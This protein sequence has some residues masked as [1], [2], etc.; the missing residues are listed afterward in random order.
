MKIL[1]ACDFDHTIIDDNSDT[2]IVQLCPDKTVPSDIKSRYQLHQS[3]TDYMDEIFK[4]MHSKDVKPEK[5]LRHMKKIPYVGG[6]KELLQFQ[7][8]TS[9][10]DCVIVSDSNKIFIDCILEDAGL[11]GSIDA[12]YTNPAEFHNGRLSVKHYHEH[13]CQRC[14]ANLCKN[15]V[16]KDH[17]ERCIEVGK[18]YDVVVVVGDGGNDFCPCTGLREEDMVFARK[19]YRLEKTINKYIADK[20]GTLKPTIKIWKHGQEI[21]TY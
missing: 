8:K 3:W 17:L 21:Q 12:V 2:W 7:G 20:Q 5:I 6:M 1:L 19:G 18:L 16:L 13:K 9:S 4:F 11:L 10:I 15:Q 14:P